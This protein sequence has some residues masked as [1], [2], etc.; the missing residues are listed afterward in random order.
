MMIIFTNVVEREMQDIL[1]FVAQI[2]TTDEIGD[3]LSK[4]AHALLNASNAIP[5]S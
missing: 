5:T 4:I 3:A 2:R 1:I